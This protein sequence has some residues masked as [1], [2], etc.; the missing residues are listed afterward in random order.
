MFAVI[1]LLI[2]ALIMVGIFLIFLN[3]YTSGKGYLIILLTAVCL[4]IPLLIKSFI[5][6]TP[7]NPTDMQNFGDLISSWYA[8]KLIALGFAYSSFFGGMFIVLLPF[9]KILKDIQNKW[10]QRKT[11]LFG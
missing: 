10:T 2:T 3:F 6:D 11:N 9:K 1:T 4:V 7:L 5:L 8:V